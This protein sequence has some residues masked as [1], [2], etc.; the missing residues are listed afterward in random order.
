MLLSYFFYFAAIEFAL[1]SSYCPKTNTSKKKAVVK[2]LWNDVILLF[3]VIDGS[4]LH[5][6]SA[7]SVINLMLKKIICSDTH[8]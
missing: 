4:H 6:S 1:T 3:D 5:A 2:L 8:F 7:F